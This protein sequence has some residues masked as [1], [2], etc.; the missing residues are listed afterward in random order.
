VPVR[1]E[2]APAKLNLALHLVG[3]RPDGLHLLDSIVAFPSLGDTVEAE[4]ARGLSLT[5]DGPFARDLDAGAGNLAL[6]AAL[7]LRA[8]GRGA[9]LRLVKSLPVAA[10]LGGGS[11]DAAATLRLL[12]RLWGVPLPGPAVVLGLGADVPACLAGG[13]ARMRGVGERLE[14]LTLPPFWVVLANPGVPLATADVFRRCAAPENPPLPAVP[15]F[16]D[17]AALAG[18]LAAQRNDLE[19]PAIAEAPVI[20]EVL[21]ALAAL[22]GCRLA[23]MSGSGATCFGLFA[24]E[25]P[26]LDAAAVLRRARPAW[27]VAAAPVRQEGPALPARP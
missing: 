5:L 27:W 10:G 11:A 23:R 18:F 9:A 19:A 6:R 8:P 20:A 24:A 14:P 13:P 12:A 7:L 26:A 17:A 15:A 16:A 1:A 22:P 2:L 3:R 21:A 25:G 4:P